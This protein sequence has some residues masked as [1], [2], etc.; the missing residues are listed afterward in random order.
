MRVGQGSSGVKV[1]CVTREG[2]AQG[3]RR[4]PRLPQ[5]AHGDFALGA[6]QLRQATEVEGGTEGADLGVGEAQ[7]RS[8]GQSGS[9]LGTSMGSGT[10][11]CVDN[12]GNIDADGVEQN[13]QVA[14]SQMLRTLRMVASAT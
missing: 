1:R 7:L 10:L 11:A 3:S 8:H 13:V 2:T 9:T 14:S 5:G 6:V 4:G 12:D